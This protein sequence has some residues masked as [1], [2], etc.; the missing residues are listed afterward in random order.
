MPK[1]VTPSMP[2]KTA[3]PGVDRRFAERLPLILQL[4]CELDDQ[5]GVLC[6]ETDEHDE[7]DLDEDVV[8]ELCDHDARESR[9]D[10][11]WNDEQNR[12]REG[13]AFV[14]SGEHQEY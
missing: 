4:L 5:D 3:M 13:P 7:A 1:I 2:L 12:G 14:L 8:V 11:H 9:E 10:A 6:R